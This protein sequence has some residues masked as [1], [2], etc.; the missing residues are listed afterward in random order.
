MKQAL[1]PD[2]PRDFPLRRGV[3]AALRTIHIFTTGV[4][5]GGHIFG[6]AKERLFG[7]LVGSVASGVV[8]LA[9]DLHATF[10]FL[11][12]VRGLLVLVKIVLTAMALFFWEARVPLLVV[13][14][15]CGAVGS[16]MPGALRHRLIL[17]QGMFTGDRRNG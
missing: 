4:L 12:Q 14:L 17:G 13:V 7:W 5:V 3:R 11:L 10:A 8:L 16:H 6:Q 15:T 1:F 2:V 9:T